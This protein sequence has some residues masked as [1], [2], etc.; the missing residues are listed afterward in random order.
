MKSHVKLLT[1]CVAI[2]L[3]AGV[4]G[5]SAT[6]DNS[7]PVNQNNKILSDETTECLECH[8]EATPFVVNDWKRSKHYFNGTGC[9]EC[10]QSDEANPAAYKHNG[11]VIST[12]VTPKQCSNCHPGVVEEYTNSIHSKSGLIAH[13]AE[14]KAGGNF[15]VIV[16]QM[17]GWEPK[18][19]I[20]HGKF[21]KDIVNDPAWP[22]AGVPE[23]LKK[24]NP[25]ANDI[26]NIF[27]GFGC[28]SCHGTVVKI[29]KKSEDKVL[30]DLATW[31]MVGAG[32]VNPDGTTG[33][34]VACHPFH[35]FKLRVV[36]AGIGACGRCH[37]SEDHP[38]YEMYG[39]SLHGAMFLS[40]A[41]EWNLDSPAI[42]AGRDYFAPTCA[43]CHMGAVY[44]GDDMIYPPTH[45]PASISKWKLGMW[46][47]TLVRKAGMSDPGLPDIKFPSDGLKNRERAMAMCGQCHTKQWVANALMNG[48]LSMATLDH[49]RQIAFKVENDL[50]KTGLNTPADRKIVRDI[51]AMAARPTGI[52]MFHYAPGYIWWEGIYK[53]AFELT[54]WLENSVEPR[55]GPEYV[56]KYVSWIKEHKE[57]VEKYRE[58]EH[59]K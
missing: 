28:Y 36:R 7:A 24:P 50:Q 45:N 26:V 46:K 59:L 51:G 48:D 57:K 29:V 34:C 30:F 38:N 32:T 22:Y 54:E 20:P 15:A 8:L 10:H 18:T 37:E 47:V 39:R 12:L 44:E 41:H 3:L 53:I 27:S 5:D 9:Y 43:T 35:G 56:S 58:K 13:N 21:W 2:V 17:M 49:F 4:F 14:A 42:K 31:P 55:L 40:Q 1:Y 25:T 19:V 33:S 16:L 52:A 23:N 6:A 11:Y